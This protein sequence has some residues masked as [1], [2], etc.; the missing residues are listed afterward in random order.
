[1]NDKYK[2]FIGESTV[3]PSRTWG[4][5]KVES[6][7]FTDAIDG[8]LIVIIGDPFSENEPL[9][10]I[11]SECVFA[12]AFDSALCD[13]A[14]QLHLAM[15][16][17]KRKGSGILFYLRIDGRGAGLSAKVKAT[18]LEV[19][20]LD[21]YESRIHIGVSPEGRDFTSIAKYLMNKNVRKIKLLTNNPKKI[22]DLE[23]EGLSVTVT[24]LKVDKEDEYIK[25]LYE[26]KSKKFG[27]IL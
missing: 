17:M 15:A 3:V 5:L 6:A 16:K 9:V 25:K 20:G 10:R 12:E 14:D 22:S 18:E 7:D 27:H 8:D 21:T 19:A 4:E 13:C 24:K 1:M 11:H 23:R 26:T 2:K